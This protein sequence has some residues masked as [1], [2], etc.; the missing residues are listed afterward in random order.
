LLEGCAVNSQCWL[1]HGWNS[2]ILGRRSLRGAGR[3]A[4]HAHQGPP[5]PGGLLPAQGQPL[6]PH[7][8]RHPAVRGPG[9]RG[10]PAGRARVRHPPARAARPAQRGRARA[11]AGPAAAGALGLV[12]QDLPAAPAGPTCAAGACLPPLA[13]RVGPSMRVSAGRPGPASEACVAGM[14]L[15]RPPPL[16]LLPL[17]DCSKTLVVGNFRDCWA[18]PWCLED[19]AWVVAC[20]KHAVHSQ[21]PVGPDGQHACC[22]AG[23]ARLCCASCCCFR[24]PCWCL[25][26]VSLMVDVDHV[27]IVDST[28]CPG[29][30]QALSLAPHSSGWDWAERDLL[31]SCTN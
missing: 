27:N 9:H 10:R 7:A 12:H 31:Q 5:L 6:P 30:E 3:A 21:F 4:D 18:S 17:V 25:H 8:G 19:C 26:H 14:R 23:R 1:M 11:R 22:M 28:R 29:T 20:M 16:H 15:W 2:S 24:C 13:L